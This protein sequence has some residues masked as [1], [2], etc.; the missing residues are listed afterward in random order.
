[1]INSLTE[2]NNCYISLLISNKHTGLSRGCNR[3]MHITNASKSI[4]SLK[5]SSAFTSILRSCFISWSV[6]LLPGKVK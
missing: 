1:M 4:I 3:V 2:T 6:M 5:L